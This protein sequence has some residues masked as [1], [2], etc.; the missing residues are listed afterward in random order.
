[1]QQVLKFIH[2]IEDLKTTLRWGNLVSNNRSESTAEHSWRLVMMA[3]VVARELRLEIN[4]D[5]AI[6]IALVH[7]LAEAITGDI[8]AEFTIGNKALTEEKRVNETKAFEDF[9]EL[10]NTELGHEIYELWLEFE[11]CNTEEG[12]FVQA[13][14][15]IEAMVHSLD[16]DLNGFSRFDLITIYA[17][18][19]VAQY[20]Q[21][22]PLLQSVKQE[23]K[24]RYEEK[25]I[26]WQ[27]EYDLFLNK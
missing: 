6:K 18:E 16:T 2:K 14:D 22:A 17:D 4:I 9:K 8:P 3:F 20:N 19:A 21:L 13:L 25:G 11:N 1:M 26:V 10:L 23:F 12:K 15:K 24:K 7:D 27:A 5:K